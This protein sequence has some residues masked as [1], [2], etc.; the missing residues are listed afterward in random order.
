MR[1]HCHKQ[2]TRYA[3]ELLD[4]LSSGP[5]SKHYTGLNGIVTTDSW[6]TPLVSLQKGAYQGDPLSVVIFNTVM[7]TL[8]DTISRRIDLGYQFSGSQRRV[9]ILQYVDNMCLVT[10]SPSS[11]Q[12]EWPEWSGMAA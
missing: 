5:F 9:N 8:V 11:C 2:F 4:L 10:T 7:N 1:N 12:A 3:R 6:E